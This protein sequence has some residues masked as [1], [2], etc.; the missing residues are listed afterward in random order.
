MTPT[1][2]T[3]SLERPRTW[4]NG[5]REGRLG[6]ALESTWLWGTTVGL[7]TWPLREVIPAGGLDPSWHLG[8]QMAL[9]RGLD[10]GTD[11]A[12]TYGPL[13][14]LDYPLVTDPEL[15]ALSLIYLAVLQIGAGL[16]LVY[17]ARRS[18]PLMVAVPFALL[19]EA[20]TPRPAVPIAIVWCLIAVTPDGPTAVRRALPFAGGIASAVLVLGKLNIGL[21]VLSLCAVTAVLMEGG[22]RRRA[23]N[24]LAFA[25]TFLLSLGVLWVALRQDLSALGEYVSA[26][27]A[28]ISTYSAAMV[29]EAAS[30][31]TDHVPAALAVI[32]TGLAAAVL[33]GR[34]MTLTRR[35]GLLLLTAIALF[36]LWKQ[37]FVR[38]DPARD[39]YLFTG[40][41]SVILAFRWRGQE[42]VYALAAVGA[43][44]GMTF[45]MSGARFD[46]KVRPVAAVEGIVDDV[47][48]VFDADR[49]EPILAYSQATRRSAYG[50][51]ARALE[52]IKGMRVHVH[53]WE[54]AIAWAYGLEWDP[55]PVFQSYAAQAPALD[56]RNA[57]RVASPE[58]PER[59]L[60]HP[61]TYASAIGDEAFAE[62]TREELQRQNAQ[63]IDGRFL[64]YDQPATTLAMLC[65]FEPLRTTRSYQVLGRVAE[66]CAEPRE[67]R[68]LTVDDGESVPVPRPRGDEIVFARVHGLE[69]SG[70]DR[71]RTL[72]YHASRRRVTF[73]SERTYRIV[74]GLASQGL[75]LRAARGV[76]FP[77]PFATS[78]D[79]HSVSF[80]RDAG[81][82]SSPGDLEIEF[83]TVA[84]GR[85][86]RE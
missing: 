35:V 66:R 65:N 31:P 67:I 52:L 1:P 2:A 16:T 18:F 19:I 50:L 12:F 70:L 17:A 82:L 30:E 5:L 69:P 45:L 62:L 15:A 86:R 21:L 8:L 23:R 24:A 75:I 29:R 63:S 54:I 53:P 25:G 81:F 80:S 78:P 37:T 14:A 10:F 47:R 51:D 64:S 76:D 77:K 61:R 11:V 26:S 39:P 33:A 84:V 28:L 36:A 40:V 22:R 49:R 83:F 41:L 48:T 38:Y 13:G 85:G 46:S 4:L 44:V 71:L 9:G 34:A 58:G 56:D 3:A 55:L 27:F 60:V 73:D 79:A 32:A 59:I 43:L 68:S 72:V 74:P 20:L 42:R 6:D 57:R 7:A